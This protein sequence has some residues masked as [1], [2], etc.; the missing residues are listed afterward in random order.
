MFVEIFEAVRSKFFFFVK[1]NIF[2]FSSKA[3]VFT[4]MKIPQFKSQGGS[5]NFI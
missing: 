2:F 4:E 1:F 5:V 3:G